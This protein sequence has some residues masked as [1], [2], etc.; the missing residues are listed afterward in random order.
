MLKKTTFI[1]DEELVETLNRLYW[2]FIDESEVDFHF[3]FNG[4]SYITNED[5]FSLE[6][7]LWLDEKEECEILDETIF[8]IIGTY[9]EFE[10][11][12]NETIEYIKE[13]IDFDFKYIS[14]DKDL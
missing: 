2:S 7:T 11:H 10:S 12:V 4:S 6:I 14:I 8:R 13:E 9:K 1:T 5:I 3:W